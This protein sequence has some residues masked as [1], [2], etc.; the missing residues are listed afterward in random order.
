MN[1][2]YFF[3]VKLGTAQTAIKF[4]NRDPSILQLI[5]FEDGLRHGDRV[6]ERPNDLQVT[7]VGGMKAHDEKG[8][9]EEYGR[10]FH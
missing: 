7:A 6:H 1:F 9:V 3:I 4:F 2:F 8:L 5:Q 10:P